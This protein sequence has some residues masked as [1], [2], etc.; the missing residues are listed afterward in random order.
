MYNRLKK[1]IATISVVCISM[2]LSAQQ[3]T[4]S[5]KMKAGLSGIAVLTYNIDKKHS[6][7]DT[8]ILKNGMFSFKGT[9]AEPTYARIIMNPAAYIDNKPALTAIDQVEFFID[10]TQITISGDSSLASATVKGG[11][12]DRDFQS[13]MKDL[14]QVG[15]RGNELSAMELKYR[16]E[17]NETGISE[18]RAEVNRLREK[19]KAIQESFMQD[20]PESFVAFSLWLRKTSGLIELPAMENEFNRFSGTIRNA[21]SGRLIAA[22]IAIAKK[23]AVGQPAI[24]FSLPDTHDKQVSLSSFK[25]KNVVLCFWYR[26]FV[27]FPTFTYQMLQISKQLKNENVALIAVYYNNSGTKSDWIDIVEENNMGSW[28]NLIDFNGLS[29]KSDNASSMAKAYDLNFGYLPQCYVLDT[30]G[31]ILSRD[32]NIAQNPVAQIKSLLGIKN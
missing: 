22:R 6:V 23:L 8:A 32:I 1:T 14:K 15:D 31:V 20:H 30:N 19:R 5:G 13:V 26:E 11:P 12:S 28:T 27:P 18:V 24:D 17:G 2:S 3:Y 21:P 16:S 10:P 25:G 7:A 9:I 4:I 29:M